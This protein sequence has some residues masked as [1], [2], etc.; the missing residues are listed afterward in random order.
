MLICS[1]SKSGILVPMINTADEAR[2]V[3]AKTKFPPVGIRGQGSP[4]A[5]F[6]HGLATPAEYV[7]R[8]NDTVLTML[9]IET[10]AGV[11][12]VEEI[13]KVDGVGE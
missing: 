3:V 9:Q 1:I 10:V 13:C 11:D 7:A 6:G 2:A 4:F 12:N 8:A 5:C